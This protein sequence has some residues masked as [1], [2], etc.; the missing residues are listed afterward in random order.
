MA[1]A[2]SSSAG[3]AGSAARAAELAIAMQE[4]TN[5]T[6]AA[7]VAQRP[8]NTI[9]AYARRQDEF[10]EWC[11]R[12]GFAEA[13]QFTVTGEKLHL[14]LV[15]EVIGRARRAT[16][17][18]DAAEDDADAA[19]EVGWSTAAIYTAAITDLYQ[20][21]KS[22][23]VNSNDHPRN[24]A[25]KTLLKT[26]ERN[27][28]ARDREQCIDRGAKT[29]ID[30]Y[31]TVDDLARIIRFY[32]GAASGEGQRNALA[33]LLSHYGLLRGESVRRVELAD[34]HA[35]QLDNEGF[36]DCFAMVM[37]M[38]Q[39]KTNQYNRLEY[40]AALRN[41]RVDVCPL[42]HMAVHLFWRW[43]IDMEPTPDFT[44]S[45]SWYFTKLITI[46]G[47]P[48][49]EISA[50][51]HS[52]FVK[53]A[54]KSLGINATATTHVSRAAGARMAELAG[55]S[56]AQ[57]RRLGR[58]TAGAMEGAYLTSLPREA[59]RAMAGFPPA[60]GSYYIARAAIE[61]CAELQR[62]V[63]PFVEEWITRIVAG[64][65]AETTIAAGKFRS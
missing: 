9:T 4:A 24:A 25:V 22:Q 17:E 50:R 45:K 47:K 14:F 51:C 30:G 1:L 33:F 54:F 37:V 6:F 39:G 63:F 12:R 13:S 8:K 2:G 31:S 5:R 61:P 27:N 55:A 57:I 3:A 44:T 62:M 65:R 34:L 58:W 64:D 26:L 42:G 7:Q 59:M 11:K 10:K 28:A 36:T 52:D 29:A 56:E 15:E 49:Q 35:L 60:A 43:Q 21:Q 23:N 46:R 19:D 48:T 18:R 38:H 16:S 53:A 32:W 40:A 20:Q 41:K